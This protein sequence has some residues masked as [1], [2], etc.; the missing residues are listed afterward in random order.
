MDRVE[1]DP[2]GLG[3]SVAQTTGAAAGMAA[4]AG[5]SGAAAAGH[6]GGGAD[7]L[8][9]AIDTVIGGWA[10]QAETIAAALAAGGTHLGQRTAETT[11]GLT[12]T[13][14]DSGTQIATITT[15]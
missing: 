10:A 3:A 6:I 13:D 8:T 11:A 1:I 4:K 2:A 5:N 12:D 15:V 14:H 7:A 9:G